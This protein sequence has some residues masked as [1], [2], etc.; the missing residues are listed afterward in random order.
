M[1]MLRAVTVLLASVV[2]A[3]PN[4]PKAQYSPPVGCIGLS[5]DECREGTELLRD[6]IR[7]T[8]EAFG[9]N[10]EKLE[11]ASNSELARINGLYPTRKGHWLSKATFVLFLEPRDGT[12]HFCTPTQVI[13]TPEAIKSK[14]NMAYIAGYIEGACEGT[15]QQILYNSSKDSR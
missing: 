8:P 12:L 1:L 15:T 10:T 14:S 2:S 4:Q 5:S 3:G 7:E 11:V 9:P 13:L 6:Y